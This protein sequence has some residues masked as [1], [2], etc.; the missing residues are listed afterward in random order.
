MKN[1]ENKQQKD[2][3]CAFTETRRLQILYILSAGQE[4]LSEL[5]LYPPQ[6]AQ[7]M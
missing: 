7:K 2:M 5:N 6:T 4:G 1:K 3:V